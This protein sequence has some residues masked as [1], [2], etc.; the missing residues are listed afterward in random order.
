MV[1]RTLKL[2]LD[3]EC[4]RPELRTFEIPNLI[5]HLRANRQRLLSALFTILRGYRQ[6]AWPGANEHL[7][8]DRLY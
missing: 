5:A 8:Q 6:A 2:T 4:E 7:L 3:P 1:R